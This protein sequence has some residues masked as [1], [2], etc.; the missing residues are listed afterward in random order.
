MP[1]LGFT[2]VGC[3]ILKY[4]N[5][6][7]ICLVTCLL[8]KMVFW[9]NEALLCPYRLGWFCSSPRAILLPETRLS[10]QKNP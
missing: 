9:D 6:L 3:G 4:V 2:H 5:Y 10:R 1:T 8:N 7:K